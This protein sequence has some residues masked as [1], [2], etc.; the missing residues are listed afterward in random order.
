MKLSDFNLVKCAQSNASTEWNQAQE[1]LFRFM[2]QVLMLRNLMSAIK[3]GDRA[4]LQ[5]GSN[6]L[7]IISMPGRC[8]DDCLYAKA[9]VG[10]E[11]YLGRFRWMYVMTLTSTFHMLNPRISGCSTLNCSTCSDLFDSDLT[12]LIIRQF[13]P[14]DF[15]LFDLFVRPVRPVRPR[16]PRE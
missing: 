16:V 13:D 8:W 6:Q 7:K 10:E 9:L 2:Q 11:F 5:S 14:F 3:Q 4:I 12:N 15:E 1:N